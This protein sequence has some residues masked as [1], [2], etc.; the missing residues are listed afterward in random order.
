[1]PHKE[2]CEFATSASLVT[3]ATLATSVIMFTL[4]T[5]FALVMVAMLCHTGSDATLSN[6]GPQVDNCTP[7][8]FMASVPNVF[9]YI[10][11]SL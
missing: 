11:C 3:M 7:T 1:M 10:L 9:S 2:Q 8:L 4:V 5:L 6:F